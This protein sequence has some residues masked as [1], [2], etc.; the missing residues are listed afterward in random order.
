MSIQEKTHYACV[1]NIRAV[2]I[3]NC[4][5]QVV[6]IQRTPAAFIERINKKGLFPKIVAHEWYVRPV[7]IY[8]YSDGESDIQTDLSSEYN[9]PYAYTDEDGKIVFN[10]THPLYNQFPPTK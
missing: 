6:S 8:T 3:P 5:S 10:E 1:L 2:D 4:H 9:I 7:S